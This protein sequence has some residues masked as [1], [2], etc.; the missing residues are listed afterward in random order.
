MMIR[1]YKHLIKLQHIH[2]EQIPLKVCE[3]EM[4]IARDYF[5]KNYADCPFYDEITQ[6][7]H[8]FQ[9]IRTEY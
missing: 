9:I 7:G 2:R 1:D 6:I 8:I 4:M 5:V 3:S